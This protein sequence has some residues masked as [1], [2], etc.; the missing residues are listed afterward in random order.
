V[1]IRD[2]IRKLRWGQGGRAHTRPSQLAKTSEGPG[3]RPPRAG[4]TPVSRDRSRTG[5]SSTS[6]NPTDRLRF[7]SRTAADVGAMPRHTGPGDDLMKIYQAELEKKG[8]WQ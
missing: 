6:L 3:G 1:K 5:G 8:T 4:A 2:R 7:E